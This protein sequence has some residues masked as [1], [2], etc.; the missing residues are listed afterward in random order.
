MVVVVIVGWGGWGCVDVDTGVSALSQEGLVRSGLYSLSTW[1][2]WLGR[3]GVGA[4]GEEMGFVP[5]GRW[6]PYYPVR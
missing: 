3:C 6:K 1:P 5:Y 2:L 4:A